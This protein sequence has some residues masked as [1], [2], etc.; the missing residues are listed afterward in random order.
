MFE[1]SLSRSAFWESAFLERTLPLICGCPTYPD[2]TGHRRTQ[3]PA[4]TKMSVI[5]FGRMGRPRQQPDL[6]PLHKQF[7]VSHCLKRGLA[8][9]KKSNAKY[10]SHRT[11]RL[12]AQV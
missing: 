12:G 2:R 6:D 11:F 8:S 1:R 10:H 9:S 7:L 3:K 4:L 5:A